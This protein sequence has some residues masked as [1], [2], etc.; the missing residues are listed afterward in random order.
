MVTGEGLLTADTE[1]ARLQRPTVQPAFHHRTLQAVAGHVAAAVDRVGADWDR[2]ID[3]AR[4]DAVIDGAVID[5]DET[6]MHAA[7]EVV[8]HA[9][10]GADLS[11]DADRLARAT[12]QALDVVIARA[13]VPITPP[14]W[15]PTV[16]NVRLRRANAELDRAV[17]AMTSARMGRSAEPD[18]PDMLDLLLAVRDDH[19][20]PL[21][22]EQ[23]RDQMVTFI[24]AGHETVASA[25]AWSWALLAAHPQW[26]QALQAEAD[27]VLGERLPTIEDYQRLPVARA[28]QD[29]ALRLYP[30]AWLITRKSRS[31]EVLGGREVPSGSLIIM[32]PWL[33]H[34]HPGVWPN[35]EQFDPARFL[36]GAAM[37]SAFIPFGAGPRL[38]I[39]RDFALVEGALMLSGLARRF[40]LSYPTGGA[41]PQ[42]EPL[43]TIR[44]QGGLPL[45]IKRRSAGAT[46]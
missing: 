41:L 36:D 6:M 39:G 12:L 29:E 28:I 11:D 26:Q 45:V 23:I 24:V 18:Q 31:A 22:Q 33:L 20:A 8:G 27:A 15:V 30:P 4:N 46:A 44:P 34:R 40:D 14:Q 32:S 42:A 25:L 17:R 35:P 38:C 19:G 43:V 1:Q 5:V 2:R 9:L 21:T 13:R 7:L 37:R 3:Q 10:F 16:G